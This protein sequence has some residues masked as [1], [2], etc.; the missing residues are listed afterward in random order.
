MKSM[1]AM[2][3]MAATQTLP[4]CGT[5]IGE[6]EPATLGTPESVIDTVVV[7]MLEN[8]SFD[9]YLGSL[10]L[11]E[12]RT[13]IMGLTADMANPDPQGGQV[14]V[15]HEA[16]PCF[17][18]P[19]HG[20]N[21][22]HAQFNNGMNDGFLS[23]FYRGPSDTDYKRVMGYFN[24][25]Q[26]PILYSMADQYTVANQ[27]FSSIMGPTWPN[28]FYAHAAQNG[29]YKG[30]QIDG[31]YSFETLYHRL[32]EQDISFACYYNNLAFMMLLQDLPGRGRLNLFE[33]FHED[34]LAGKLPK[35]SVIEPMYGR[36]CDHPPV[37]PMAGQVLM[38]SVIDS[39]SKSPQWENSLLII[40]YDE[41]GGYFDHVAPPKT[42]DERAADGFDQLGFRVPTVFVG[43][44]VK[45]RFATNTVYNHA[46]ILA[47]AERLWGLEPLNQR[48]AAASDCFDVLD[49]E[50]IE[51]INPRPPPIIPTVV[52]DQ[53]VFDTPPCGSYAGLSQNGMTGQPELE[54]FINELPVPSPY[55]RRSQTDELY[56]AFLDATRE[57]GIWREP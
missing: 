1:A 33:E 46:S 4:G 8:R 6:T 38:A 35:F 42:E 32:Y 21:A 51:N 16:A 30:N 34:A 20:W 41:H 44:Y 27:W 57:R 9:H 11:L 13:D 31:D 45:E 56:Q 7:L 48:D 50:R 37:H 55:D 2:A 14:P 52:A 15:Y 28:R 26:L 40:T 47:L 43:P 5:V 22:S 54:R 25:E 12:G 17:R 49:M 29:G 24:R 36:N 53:A 19:P 3:A 18:D 10:S 39:L 23:E